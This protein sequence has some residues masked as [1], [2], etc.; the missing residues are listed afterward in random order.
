MKKREIFFLVVFLIFLILRIHFGIDFTDELQ[1]YG[2]INSL[3]EHGFLFKSDF[4]IQ[5]LCYVIIL[6][7]VILYKFL[8][9]EYDYFILF[10]RYSFAFILLLFMFFLRGRFIYHKVAQETATIFS[11]VMCMVSCYGV[12]GFH[13]NSFMF[14][15]VCSSII[16]L[17]SPFENDKFNLHII[18]L[19]TSILLVTYPTIGI[20][21]FIFQ[22]IYN[23]HKINF[24]LQ[25]FLI[26][27]IFFVLIFLSGLSSLESILQSVFLS[28]QFLT[29]R[30]F[31]E[32]PPLTFLFILI[33][34]LI[35]LYGLLKKRYSLIKLSILL[36]LVGILLILILSLINY[37]SLTYTI[38]IL[39]TIIGFALVKLNLNVHNY[40]IPLEFKHT[41]VFFG[42][43]F[44]I[45]N[46]TGSGGLQ[47]SANLSLLFIPLILNHFN[48]K[49]CNLKFKNFVELLIISF[50]LILTFFNN[51][52][53]PRSPLIWEIGNYQNEIPWFKGIFISDTKES[54]LEIVNF[55]NL[56]IDKN[57]VLVIG[58]NPWLYP[59][60]NVVPETPMFFMHFTGSPL[61]EEEIIN[62]II[63][64]RPDCI[65]V[66][67]LPNNKKRIKD[68][69]LNEYKLIK[70]YKI[71]NDL[72]EDYF[73]E[74]D[75]SLKEIIVYGKRQS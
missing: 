67:G 45:I 29:S 28:S 25:T 64:S 72:S 49:K 31:F 4:F 57:K 42:I 30:K 40:K 9:I 48:H 34:Y 24:C 27:L 21:V 33:N 3:A 41:V 70:S 53:L 51:I 56:E 68:K 15:L 74:T 39:L 8:F 36:A 63:N 69:L 19:I 11:I 50:L 66:T 13:Y 2:E 22:L 16:V 62:R 65:I 1:Y 37:R 6:P 52:K 18:S 61:A 73:K 44:F 7:L 59:S 38:P 23:K 35:L 54:I 46:Y 55:K 32:D 71:P 12:F 20:G 14:L 10:Y 60:L 58:P 47:K 17:I 26:V 75:Y 43:V 5:Q